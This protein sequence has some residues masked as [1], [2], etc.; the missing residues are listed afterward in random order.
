MKAL[1]TN[2]AGTPSIGVIF[3][4]GTLESCLLK[5]ALERKNKTTATIRN[6]TKKIPVGNVVFSLLFLGISLIRY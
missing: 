1:G 2:V 4:I 5:I 3:V 6:T